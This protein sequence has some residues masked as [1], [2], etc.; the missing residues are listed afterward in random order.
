MRST[1]KTE[2]ELP[3]IHLQRIQVEVL[4]NIERLRDQ[5]S[6]LALSLRILEPLDFTLV[7]T[8]EISSRRKRCATSPRP[9][10]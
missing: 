7:S 1:G 3:L 8:G 10:F 9:C 2:H 4:G 6:V 5:A